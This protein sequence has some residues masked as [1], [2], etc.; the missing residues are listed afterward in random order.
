MGRGAELLLSPSPPVRQ[1]GLAGGISVV[2]CRVGA[3]ARDRSGTGREAEPARVESFCAGRR[4]QPPLP[5]AGPASAAA[6]RLS[7][8]SGSA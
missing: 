4:L 1:P 8:V 5:P 3:A 7:G 6:Q 2:A